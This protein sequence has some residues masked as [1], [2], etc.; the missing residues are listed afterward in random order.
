MPLAVRS[1]AACAKAA[2]GAM[3]APA[4]SGAASRAAANRRRARVRVMAYSRLENRSVGRGD[5]PQQPRAVGE[6]E[7]VVGLVAIPQPLEDP[8]ALGVEMAF[9]VADDHPALAAGL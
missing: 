3:A 2:V 8:A 1:K 5:H 4:Q 9:L 7:A 6:V